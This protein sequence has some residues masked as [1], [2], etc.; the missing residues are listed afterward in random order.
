MEQIPNHTIPIGGTVYNT[1]YWLQLARFHL[2]EG[3]KDI[4]MGDTQ[5]A[6]T[7][8]DMANSQILRH[9]Q[10]MQNITTKS[11][12]SIAGSSYYFAPRGR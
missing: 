3:I 10:E 6:L 1:T 4:K 9:V 12:S 11:S 8:L 2:T 7:Q 5:T